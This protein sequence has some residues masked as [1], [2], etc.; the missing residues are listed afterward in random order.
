MVTRRTPAAAVT[1]RSAHVLAATAAVLLLAAAGYGRDAGEFENFFKSMI[2]III[3]WFI[4]TCYK[5]DD[6]MRVNVDTVTGQV[7]TYR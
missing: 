5:I 6:D 3:E 4:V 2:F 1:L 7:N